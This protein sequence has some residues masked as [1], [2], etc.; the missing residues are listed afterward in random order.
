MQL[1]KYD[2]NRFKFKLIAVVLP[3]VQQSCIDKKIY[4]RYV[5]LRSEKVSLNEFHLLFIYGYVL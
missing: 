5:K 2:N 1:Q 3:M 4:F